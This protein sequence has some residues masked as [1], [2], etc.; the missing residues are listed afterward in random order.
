MIHH[1]Y[2]KTFYF[3]ITSPNT[4]DSYFIF[5]IIKKSNLLNNIHI[6]LLEKEVNNCWSSVN[7]IPFLVLHLTVKGEIN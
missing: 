4:M 6:T 3:K 1:Y 7:L 5:E 2:Q